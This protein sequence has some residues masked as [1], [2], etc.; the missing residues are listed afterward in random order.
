MI[1]QSNFSQPRTDLSLSKTTLSPVMK[2]SA[3]AST[4]TRKRV[5]S[6]GHCQCRRRRSNPTE[7]AAYGR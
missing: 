4:R 2:F 3:I 1:L 7:L 6:T 5:R